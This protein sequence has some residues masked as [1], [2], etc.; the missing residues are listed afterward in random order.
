[1]LC[2]LPFSIDR[3]IHR[4]WRFEAVLCY[5]GTLVWPLVRVM[6]SS[7]VN[8][9]Q[10]NKD[11]SLKVMNM[12]VSIYLL[13]LLSVDRYISIVRASF[14]NESS[15]NERFNKINVDGYT[16]VHGNFHTQSVRTDYKSFQS[17]V[18]HFF[19]SWPSY[20]SNRSFLF[21]WAFWFGFSR[22]SRS[23]RTHELSTLTWPEV[24]DLYTGFRGRSFSPSLSSILVSNDKK[25][26]LSKINENVTK[27]KAGFQ[28]DT[29]DRSDWS[30]Q[31][32]WVI[33]KP[34]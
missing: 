4:T 5:L 16:N 34:V 18:V 25:H 19:I 30:L 24:L 29:F 10:A 9:E 7:V 14:K 32:H 31:F 6:D 8:G 33:W 23:V 1:M 20:L 2:F 28:D 27:S 12:Y 13:T 15:H 11:N 22:L 21:F 3:R 17:L 26:G